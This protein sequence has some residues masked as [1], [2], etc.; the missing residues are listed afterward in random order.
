MDQAVSLVALSWDRVPSVLTVLLAVAA[1][2][3]MGELQA[4]DAAAFFR[5][6]CY[7][8]HTIGGGRVTGPDLRNVTQRQERSWLVHFIQNPK[9]VIDAGDTYAQQLVKD[10]RGVIM[11]WV[12]GLD[13]NMA[14]ALL[15]LVQ[16][17]GGLEESNFMGLQISDKPISLEQVAQGRQV[18]FG[19]IRLQNGGP[20]CR[21]CHSVGGI[22]GFGGGRIGPD[23]TKVYE[24]LGGRRA[25]ASWLLAPATPTMST[26]FRERPLGQEDITMIAAFLEDSSKN[27]VEEDASGQRSGILFLGL[28]GSTILLAA[29]S[30]LW[31]DCFSDG[32]RN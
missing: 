23:L 16:K 27:S 6:N 21:S 9:A 30:R 12:R 5:S 20:A 14:E 31:R 1:L 26:V 22:G 10:A 17:E 25:L 4:Q 11:P 28:V 29:A 18:F 7:S 24:R 15:D 3:M 8:C 19:S 2:V 32:S 13:Q